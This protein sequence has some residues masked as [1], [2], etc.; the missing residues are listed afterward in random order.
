MAYQHTN[1]KG[2]TYN[3]HKREITLKGS[4]KKQT[5]Y[6]FGREVQDGAIDGVPSGYLV[7]ES[8]KT[9]LPVLKKN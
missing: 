8:K 2:E 7:V 9:G 4:G 6:F 5:I 1:S 3:L